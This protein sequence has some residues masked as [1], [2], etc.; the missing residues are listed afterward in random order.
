MIFSHAYTVPQQFNALNAKY[1]LRGQQLDA[2]KA[3]NAGLEKAI[4]Q[5]RAE[6]QAERMSLMELEKL[7]T[8]AQQARTAMEAAFNKKIEEILKENAKNKDHEDKDHQIIK[9]LQD[10]I[11]SERDKLNDRINKLQQD[12]NK[13]KAELINTKSLLLTALNE[14]RSLKRTISQLEGKLEASNSDRDG[15]RTKVRVLEANKKKTEISLGDAERALAVAKS[16]LENERK[17]HAKELADQKAAADKAADKA[18]E[19]AEA[20][21][22]AKAEAEAEIQ[23]L[24][25]QIQEDDDFHEQD[26]KFVE[27]DEQ[28]KI[29]L[30]RQYD[31]LTKQLDAPAPVRPVWKGRH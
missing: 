14:V 3:K 16:Q 26:K 21:A 5:T 20:A 28:R 31:E 9:K 1:S 11:A 15:L 25:A 6:L 24:R 17:Q 22:K 10:Q 19:A 29:N 12:L 4:D 13:S 30:R 2:V 8:A 18:A 23:K 27:D 7:L